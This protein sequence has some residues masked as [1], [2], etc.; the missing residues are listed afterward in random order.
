MGQTRGSEPNARGVEWLSYLD[1]DEAHA[2]PLPQSLANLKWEIS[3][4]K[5]VEAR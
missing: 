3:E 4:K 5:W 1:R 2:M